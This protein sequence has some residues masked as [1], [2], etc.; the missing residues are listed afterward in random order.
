MRYNGDN[1]DIIDHYRQLTVNVDLMLLVC[2]ILHIQYSILD[3][4]ALA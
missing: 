4:T 1:G 3:R 2:C